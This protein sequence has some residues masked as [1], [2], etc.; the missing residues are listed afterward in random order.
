L[1]NGPLVTSGDSLGEKVK[2]CWYGPAD[3]RIGSS[4]MLYVS[5]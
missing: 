2:F 5:S 4:W 1:E 3:V